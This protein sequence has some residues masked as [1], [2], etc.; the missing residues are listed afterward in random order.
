LNMAL[1]CF[2][3]QGERERQGVRR[4]SGLLLIP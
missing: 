4:K 1:F 3:G 2:S